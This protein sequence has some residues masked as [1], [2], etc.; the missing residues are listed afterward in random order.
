MANIKKRILFFHF[1][2]GGGGAERVLVNLLN[3]L[4]PDKYEI[5]LHTIF[6]NGVYKNAIA[7]HI[8]R[9]TVFKRQFRGVTPFLKLFSP[10]FL[11]KFLIKEKY[12]IEIAYLQ[13]TP[14][15]IISG[16]NSSAIKIGWL[17]NEVVNKK[18]YMQQAFR[19]IDESIVCYNKF[20][21]IVSVAESVQ[22]SF[23][24]NFP[25][26]LTPKKVLYNVNDY[27][28][29]RD[30]SSKKIPLNI[31]HD[32]INICSVGRLVEQKRFDRLINVVNRIKHD[33]IKL[34]LYILGEGKERA[35]LEEQ[36]GKLHLEENVSLLGFNANPYKYVAKMDLFV[37]SSMNE[38]YSTAVTEAVALGV[39]VLTTNCSGMEEILD[40]GKYGKI[41]DNN[42]DA[43]YSGI[44]ELIENPKQI[45]DYRTNIQRSE[46]FDTRS[47]VNQYEAFFDSL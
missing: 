26:I 35:N 41:V 2:L 44:K 11:H 16:C 42:E 9:K 36:I 43:L 25:E 24:K 17:H 31:N 10:S 18:E 21:Y 14:T 33:N 37:C 28:E 8:K 39:P 5:T 40:G 12:D 1:S 34:H 32:T 7:G 29:I 15:R 20:H 22:D 23:E 30:L 47:L 6:N 13:S 46:K 45:D 3:N 4:D 38:G 27:S 19:S